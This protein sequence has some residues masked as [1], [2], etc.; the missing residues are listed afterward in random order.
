MTRILSLGALALFAISAPAWAAT[1]SVGQQA[2]EFGSVNW[3]M[4]PPK[5]ESVAKLKGEVIF[6]ERWGVKCPPC[7]ALIPHIEKLQQTYGQ[8]GLHIFTF[9]AQNH[10]PD[11]I[12]AK[13]KER[14]GKTYPVAAGGGNNYRGDGGIPV[15]WLIGVDGTVIWQGNPAAETS[16]L[17]KLI[18]QEV[19]KV[20]FP[21]LGKTD[22]DPAVL[23]AVKRYMGKDFGGAR[24]EAGKITADEG[25]SS[26]A[27]EDAQYLID[28]VDELAARQQKLIEDYQGEGKH[29]EAYQTLGFLAKAFKG[30]EVGDAAKA[31]LKQYKKDKQLKKELA[32]ALKLQKLLAK[33]EG[34]PAQVRAK[35]LEKFA[36]SRK[37]EGTAAAA[38]ASSL[39]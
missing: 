20:R 28:K 5:V 33:L 4:N 3:V 23:G 19:A 10:T 9:E 39:K 36:T 35:V 18:E 37:N 15:A 31:G 1:P 29:L 17:D 14:G 12:R 21:G 6:V 13:I 30:S 27:K 38:R 16:K 22:F 7:V 24:K 8:R 11:Q 25:A 2:P 32:A 34:Q 26:K